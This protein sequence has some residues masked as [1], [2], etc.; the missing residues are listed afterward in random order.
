M[1]TA[2]S[3]NIVVRVNCVGYTKFLHIW[4]C[5]KDPVQGFDYFFGAARGLLGWTIFTPFLVEGEL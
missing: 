1:I 4:K 2:E 5:Q 3:L